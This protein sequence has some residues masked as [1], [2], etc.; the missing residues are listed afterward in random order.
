LPAQRTSETELEELRGKVAQLSR[1]QPGSKYLQRQLKKGSHEVVALILAEVE[2]D[3]A[4]LMCDSYGNYLCSAI[5][6]ECH[7]PQR[8]RMLEQLSPR[9]SQ[10]ACDKRG[11]HAL[12]SLIRLVGAADE[13]RLLME[14]VKPHV[15]ALSMD[16]NGTHVI[17]TL[18]QKFPPWCTAIIYERIV[19]R[20]A[21]VARHA[22][23]LC[24]LKCCISQA[25]VEQ[26]YCG[27]VHEL[28]MHSL[29]LVQNEY[30]N[31]AVQH[32]LQVWGGNVCA[33]IL[34]RLEGQI[35][36]LSTQKCSSNVVEKILN[37]APPD[38]RS[39]FIDE[40]SRG[41]MTELLK[42][43][44]G[45]YVVKKAL[46]LADPE[47]AVALTG[48]IRCSMA[49]LSTRRHRTK[50]EKVLEINLE[51]DTSASFNHSSVELQ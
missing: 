16:A 36:H 42:S 24:A 4:R 28:A 19:Q 27:L 29:E 20:M 13:Q 49:Q 37:V 12:Q 48:A 38:L 9:I 34:R 25:V 40:L 45:H 2:Q 46:Q 51:S 47:Q 23:G 10:I 22:Y 18:L 44:Y 30:G 21:E 6:K 33:P 3:V 41:E 17:Q 35:M 7:G 5:F 31:Y 15:I 1:T 39:R 26:Q 8:R 50:W 14:A 32:A 43:N 11:T